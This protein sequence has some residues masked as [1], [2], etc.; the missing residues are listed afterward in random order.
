M[1]KLFI[2]CKRSYLV[3]TIATFAML[4]LFTTGS[5]GQ[6]NISLN[7]EHDNCAA[8]PQSGTYS[9]QG[10][11]NGKPRYVKDVNHYI[12]WSGSRWEI[13]SNNSLSNS[14]T[15]YNTSNTS[16]LP[17]SGWVASFGCFLPNVT[18]DCVPP[19]NAPTKVGSIPN[20]NATEN[21]PNTSVNLESYFSDTEDGAAG[22]SYTK[23]TTDPTYFT[24]SINTSNQLIIDYA[25][26]GTGGPHT[27]TIRATDTGGKYVE[28]SFTVNVNSPGT[29]TIYPTIDTS[30][31]P[32]DIYPAEHVCYVGYMDGYG[33]AQAVLKLDLSGV[34]GT[35]TAAKLR[36]YISGI[37]YA[38]KTV[39]VKIWGSDDDSWTASTT[40]VPEKRTPELVS[41]TIPG[42]GWVEFDVSSFVSSEAAGNKVV[43][44]V[45]TGNTTSV[46][47]SDFWFDASE[48]GSNIPE[49][50][51]TTGLSNSTPTIKSTIPNLAV[52]ENAAS[53][54]MNLE[55]YFDDA[56]D[57]AAGLTY[58]LQSTDPAFFST[59]IASNVLTIDYAA[60]GTGGP[61]TVTVRATDSQGLYKEQ[62]F[63]VTVSAGNV[64]FAIAGNESFSEG[65]TGA[66]SKTFTITKTGSTNF[67]SQVNFALSGTAT[68]SKDFQN[69]GG[70]SGASTTN[71]T[72]TF[73]PGETTK[74][75]T[76][77]VVGN[78]LDEVDRN[79][80]VTLSGAATAGSGS[81]SITTASATKTIQDDDLPPTVALS[82]DKATVSENGGVAVIT[83]S[84]NA[85]SG[86]QVS[87][88]LSFLGTALRNTDFTADNSIVIPAGALSKS[89]SLTATNDALYEGDEAVTV[90]ISSVTNATKEGTSQTITLQ[91][92]DA[93][94]TV[95]LSLSGSPMAE[96]AG[97]AMVT[98]NLSAL[99]AKQTTISL[100]FAGTAADG[101]D[102]S[103]PSNTISIPAGTA[104]GSVTLTAIDDATGEADETIVVDIISVTNGT[105]DGTQQVTATITDDDKFSQTVDFQAIGP[106]AYGD[107]ALTLS[108]TASSGL[109]L[110][111]ESSDASIASISGNTLSIHKAGNVTV[112]AIQDGNET[113]LSAEASQ[114][115]SISKK[116]LTVTADDKSRKYGEANP[117]L[118]ITY[119][120]FVTGDNAASLATAPVASTTADATT[121]VGT[122]AIAVSGGVDANYD[123]TYEAGVLTIEK[124][125]LTVTADNKSKLYGEANPAL[126]IT[127][128]GFANGETA[129]VLDVQP[130]ISTTADASSGVGAYPINVSGG[131]DDNYSFSAYQAASLTV[132]KAMLFATAEN[133]NRKYGEANPAFTYLLSGFVNGETD[134]VLD[135][136]PTAGTTADATTGA[137]SYPISVSGG[138]DG[139]YAFTYV[140][141]T[142]TIEKAPLTVSVDNKT[143]VYGEANP[144]LT[145]SYTGFVNGETVAVLNTAPS[146]ATSATAASE[147]GVYTIEVSGGVD[148]NYDFQYIFGTLTIEKAP[149]A[150]SPDDKSRKYGEAN[151]V[152]TLSYNGFVNG[153]DA[154]VLDAAPSASTTATAASPAGAYAIEVAGGADNNYT[155]SYTAGTLTINK[156]T[157][158]VTADDKSKVYGETN[159]ALTFSYA[160]FVN[161]ETEAVLDTKPIASTTADAGTAAGSYAIEVAGG[162]DDNYQ[163]TYVAATLTIGKAQLTAK[164]DDKSR[165]YGEANPALT[166]TY[167]GF[168]NGDDAASLATAPLA[169]TA[170]DASTGVGT[171]AIAV[172]GG[173]DANYD[174]TYEGGVLTIEKAPL[175][176]TADNKSKL[177][178]AVNP[179]LTIT[180]TGF[181]NGEDVTVLNTA[182]SASTTATTTSAVGSYAITV[183]GGADDHYDFMYVNGSLT[184]EKPTLTVSADAKSKVYG[185][186]N[187]T[188][189]YQ[190]SGFVGGDNASVLDVAPVATT[191]ADAASGAGEYT[192]T[193]G[194]GVDNNYVFA[195]EASKLTIQKASL[196][197]SVEDQSRLYGDANPA[198]KLTYTGFV[199]GD[200]PD[201]LSTPP[202]ATTQANAASSVGSYDII[203]SGGSDGNYEF[204][205]THGTLSI[206][207]ALLSVT[208]DDKSR[209]YGAE[210]PDF[211]L[212]YAGFK[213]A[214]G[215]QAL[216]TKPVASS[217]TTVSSDAGSYA[218]SLSA[219]QDQNYQ[220][221]Y[222]EG[223][224]T[225]N[226]ALLTV[227]ALDQSRAYTEANP[228]LTFQYSGFV[229]NED[230]HVLDTRPAAYTTAD[231][232]SPVG[233]YQIEVNGGA[234]QNYDFTYEAAIL[235]I[236]NHAPAFVKE[237]EDQLATEDEAFGFTID[238]QVFEEG[239]AGDALSYEATLA[240]G[241]ALPSWIHFDEASRTFSGTPENE[242]VGTIEVKVRATDKAGESAIG[243]FSISIANT[244]DAPQLVIAIPN[245]EAYKKQAFQYTIAAGS[246]E[247]VDQG[248]ALRF[249]ARLENG[250][251]LPAWLSFDA[252]RQ[253]FSGRPALE[254]IGSLSIVVSATDQ[255][256]SSVTDAFV[257]EV[258]DPN[259]QPADINL[260][261][262]EVEENK[263]AGTFVGSFTTQDG[264]EDN[265]HTYR[266]VDGEEGADNAYFFIEGDELFANANFDAEV[267]ASYSIR[268]EVNDG[269]DG[270]LEKVFLIE[271]KNVED[272]RVYIPN[273]FSPNGDGANDT[274]RVRANGVAEISLRIFNR[275]GEL[276]FETTNVQQATE[277]G[278][279][280]TYKGKQQPLG[281][282]VWQLM[283]RF[284]D[285]SPIDFEGKNS[286]N[287]TLIR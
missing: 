161:G 269:D 2:T 44:L 153:E 130:L 215:E 286:G 169:S 121:G 131:S 235:T 262:T 284:S 34:S 118:T 233:T 144:T 222:S 230:E 117:A 129:A 266:L 277:T 249:A 103:Y 263:P 113:Y 9:P 279:D 166:I 145:V 212:S 178:G 114:S 190:I 116:M 261:A 246:F 48:K 143:K 275:W 108:A 273:L 160:G 104:S 77:D 138:T 272:A 126:T 187:P 115:L 35:V 283:G 196:A 197:V 250:N 188:L 244:N 257:L 56:E 175:T 43:T 95:S 205:Y 82:L 12:Q 162:A 101:V 1:N 224:L 236:Y 221:T 10:T 157:L 27:V 93:A 146:A 213:N 203:L 81:A 183:S 287:I 226:K 192:I 136:E 76:V 7:F 89:I 30:I 33:E 276:L 260:S 234:D 173:V 38:G 237:I 199:N 86:K 141:A 100:A 137:G 140:A 45:V 206:Q 54:T 106:K 31:D 264:D 243:Q 240:D 193:V 180:Y 84:L 83:A 247:D 8:P 68:L 248:D 184:I 57:G 111:F 149:L 156:A 191:A 74:T 97:Q 231:E 164:A 165:K 254:D 62:S 218:I 16:K 42:Y 280:G 258:S 105:E 65:N 182:P 59:S 167:A 207:K 24:A 242:D 91:D 55:S 28:Q 14:M 211:T 210:N 18:G 6:G 58:S 80:V 217:Q 61:A 4:I 3:I 92:D 216:D 19:N 72:I 90:D 39:P 172:A 201:D 209:V 189:T 122:V 46:G 50:V 152:L 134:A 195:Y 85:A 171:V 64:S 198:F 49:L 66:L 204:T 78:T 267:K 29:I 158:T 151:P 256:N 220:F 128:T 110:R 208:A 120:G 194:G 96:N 168:V 278:W 132:N 163:F 252:A 135:T 150:V 47:E 40:I 67:S 176:V 265:Q 174:F 186:D 200:Q 219:G 119:T 32:Y 227:K 52:L 245:Q 98:A 123:F 268:V 23:Q 238:S 251:A 133:K 170:A 285:G 223:V 107:A 41:A 154:S 69:I 148:E 21:D 26:T 241:T 185:V 79:M 63:T 259:Q 282:Y 255:S 228:A 13:Y 124:A 102:Y 15:H 181:V 155:L 177:Y 127:Y 88:D 94:P 75:I 232:A 36:V 214:D 229:L 87:L 239:D 179:A 274:F 147:V 20:I 53:S 11:L 25:T 270:L 51:I 22:L 112:K 5:Y 109:P 99:S 70:T 139:N 125:A 37:S 142:L 17:C 159:P 60:T 73:G 202:V 271:V 71:G 253:T 225:V 281:S